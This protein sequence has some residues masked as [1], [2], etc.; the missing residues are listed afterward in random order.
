M[1]MALPLGVDKVI[2]FT[3]YFF[4]AFG[5][6]W[7][8][9]ATRFKMSHHLMWLAALIG[10]F[11]GILDEI[12]QS[13]VPGREASAFDALADGVGSVVGA[14]VGIVCARMLRREC[15][16]KQTVRGSKL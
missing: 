8:F 11:Y 7:A 6:I 15:A 2:H 13:F 4:L 14:W 12:H 10:F 9:R 16:C 3:M 1:P 5:L